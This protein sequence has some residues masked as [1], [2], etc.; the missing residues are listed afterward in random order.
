MRI[1]TRKLSEP[2]HAVW[3]LTRKWQSE[4]MVRKWGTIPSWLT[5]SS[6]ALGGGGGNWESWPGGESSQR[7]SGGTRV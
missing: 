7:F 3:K 5:Q 1:K 4:W 6:G 2:Q